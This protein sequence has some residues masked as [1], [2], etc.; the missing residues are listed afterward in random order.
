MKTECETNRS[1]KGIR[2]N[3]RKFVRNLGHIVVKGKRWK[4]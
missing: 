3:K 1:G 2:G 4:L